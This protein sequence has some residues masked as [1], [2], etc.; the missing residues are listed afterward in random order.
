MTKKHPAQIKIDKECSIKD[1][2]D[3]DKKYARNHWVS[4]VAIRPNDNELLFFT[5]WGER[6]LTNFFK[7]EYSIKK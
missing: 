6:S 2:T 3:E 4:T 5:P 7:K 1:F